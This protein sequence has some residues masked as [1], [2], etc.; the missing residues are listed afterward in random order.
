M[1]GF[2]LRRRRATS[3]SIHGALAAAALA[4][5]FMLRF[6]FTLESSYQ[7]MLME[8]LPVMLAV[9][10][11]VFRAF[12]LR[13][14][15]WRYLGFEDLKRMAAANV[16][17]SMLGAAA[18]RVVIGN[19][20]PRSIYV[21]DWL[22]CLA[23]MAALRAGVRIV[24]DHGR[25]FDRGRS[26]RGAAPPGTRAAKRILIYGAGEAGKTILSEIR[27]HPRMG[28]QA[29]GFL[30]DDPE[31]RHLRLNGMRVLGKGSEIA[32][33]ARRHKIDEV[34][35]AMP[36]AT[37]A[38]IAVILEQCHA[39]RVVTR[40]IP[41]LAELIENQ[42]LADQIREVRLEDLLGRP[43]ADLDTAEIG[44]RLT[45]KVVLVTGAG[46]SIGGELC[47]QIARYRPLALIGV[48]HA[49]SA[50]YEIDQEM[51]EKYSHV[52]FCPEVGNIQ[53]RRR[54]DEIFRR[55]RPSAVYHA[56]AYKH[57]PMMESHVIEAIENNVFG[58]GNVARAAMAAGA[59]TFVL[60]S[61]DKAVRPANIMGATKRMAEL[62]CL[63]AADSGA[64]T[65]FLAVRFGNV[66]GSN[67][68]VI[69]LFKR[70]IAAGGP[71]TV[72]HPEMRRFF[73]TV[74]EAAQLVLQT[75]A[76]GSGGEVFVLDMGQPVRIVDLARKMIL[77]SGRKP[78]QDIRIEFSG[79]RPG[80]KLY[81]EVSAI[82]EG[83][84][85]TPHAQ[86]RVFTGRGV[87]GDVIT[88]GLKDLHRSVEAR[89]AAGAVLCLKEMI[90]D[91]N[92]SSFVL[93]RAFEQRAGEQRAGDQWISA[94]AGAG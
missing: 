87:A 9:K 37:G 74:S 23:A 55:H 93:R 43:P 40:K 45:G 35:L 12:G 69:P 52:A 31:K 29:A 94:V 70:Q 58:T 3:E 27:A 25:G 6:E 88:G 7:T 41:P 19:A 21:L 44:A 66:L 4:A 2:L 14:L 42:V 54:L 10:L 30:D 92:P 46:G 82:E 56:A 86:I 18:L 38:Q 20:F 80:E 84:V 79:V 90:P 22:V 26:D 89:D 65:R 36:A 75:A 72:T 34:L 49:E 73:M 16:V 71:V 24:F 62:V 39:A 13:D 64:R 76:M 59:D 91:Y 61:S 32:A 47:R 28:Y 85:S 68:S 78:D 1:K 51:R 8:A 48:D 53:N 33:L 63:A 57:V 17:A 83:T 15:G 5:S 81:E 50:L 11:V 60:V 67:G 77:L